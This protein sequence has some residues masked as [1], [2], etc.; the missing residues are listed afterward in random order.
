[1]PNKDSYIKLRKALDSFSGVAL[2][3]YNLKDTDENKERFVEFVNKKVKNFLGELVER[4]TKKWLLL[5][6]KRAEEFENHAKV[7][8][9]ERF[10]QCPPGFHEV[11]GICV[12][13]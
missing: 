5:A 1:M 3:E 12:P 8:I 6:P 7:L 11:D 9:A 13:I 10:P 4:E 2:A